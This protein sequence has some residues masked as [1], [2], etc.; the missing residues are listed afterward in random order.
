MASIFTFSN[1][2][3]FNGNLTHPNKENFRAVINTNP[4][5]GPN[6][7]EV[8]I[9]V[10]VVELWFDAPMSVEEEA[11]LRAL[12]QSKYRDT[13]IFDAVVDARGNGDYV[14]VADAFADGKTSVYVRDGL[15]IE[16]ANIIIPDGGQLV[17]ES[18]SNV[19]IVLVA[20]NSVVVDGSQG[21]KINSGTI[22]IE[23][24]TKNIVGTGTAFT[25]LLPSSFILLGTNFYQ[26][27]S[28][29]S[30]TRL[31]L[32]DIYKGKSL[33][34]M[35]CLAQKMFTG[36]KISNIIIANSATTGLYI[37]GVRHCGFTGIAVL[38]CTPNIQVVDSGDASL[39]EFIVG[40]SN[41]TGLVL[42][43]AHSM[44]C[45][46][47]DI[48]NS[49]M[50]GI[51][52][53]SKSSSNVFD[54]CSTSNNAGVGFYISGNA[55]DINVADTVIKHN[56]NKG[57]FTDV[58]SYQIIISGCT[59]IE[60]RLTGLH[61]C[62]AFGVISNN[63]I[64]NNGGC[65]L[66]G[67]QKCTITS[68]QI[69]ENLADGIRNHETDSVVITSNRIQANAGNGIDI[70]TSGSVI[71]NNI[72]C[73]CTLSGLLYGGSNGNV[74]N[75][76]ISNNTD[77]IHATETATATVV[78]QNQFFSNSSNGLLFDAGSSNNLANYNMLSN[79]GTN[80]TDNGTAN[81]FYGNKVL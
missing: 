69:C 28:V 35:F 49:T 50:H 46:T 29:E 60:N 48:Y 22:A 68:N 51:E 17:G 19:K 63:V 18:Q 78:G 34:N 40:F 57:L 70:K 39:C 44:L 53:K 2:A 80:S 54:S 59:V 74:C 6:C 62:G 12:V 16:T 55:S 13:Y 43:N 21:V 27:S 37:R 81:D 42:E 77:G 75:N 64:K 66:E 9:N 65:G 4:N 36:I 52:L 67:G 45:A 76:V 1:I 79:N 8:K 25:S 20:G 15:Y 5:I 56:N 7:D 26:I 47:L 71:S 31:T 11:V 33:T 32:R 41:G 61:L 38:N 23:H 30:D 73:N 10:D 72:I 14:R 24:D 3:D 58:G